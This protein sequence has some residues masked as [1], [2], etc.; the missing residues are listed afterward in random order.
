MK[1]ITKIVVPIDFAQNCNQLID[2]AVDFAGKFLSTKVNFIHVVHYLAGRDIMIGSTAVLNDI[3][4]ITDKIKLGMEAKMATVVE[5]NQKKGIDCS[6]HVV[7]GDTVG[8]IVDYAAKQKASLIVIATHGT[9]S[10]EE[11]LLGSV[12]ERVIKR[13]ACPVL[14]FNP[15]K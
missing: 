2:F 8:E 9:K 3:S 10:L 5:A 15:Y 12:A 6:G 13:A 1:E 14:T 4:T 11:I 7:I